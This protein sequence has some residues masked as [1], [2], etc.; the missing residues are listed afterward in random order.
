MRTARLLMLLAVLLTLAVAAGSARSADIGPTGLHADEPGRTSF[1]RTPSFAWNPVP[2][3][4]HYEFQLSLSTTFRD[5]SVI[6]ADANATTP[7]EAPAL[8]LPWITGSPHALYA[9][10][11]AVT[12]DGTTPWS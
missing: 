11:R 1:S 6:Y 3:A 4:L 5:N 2:G 10:V 12:A 9:R 7:V 8:T